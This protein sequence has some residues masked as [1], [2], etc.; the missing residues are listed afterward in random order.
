M[1]DIPD[2]PK[3][4]GLG[5][6]L[7][8]MFEICAAHQDATY[9]QRRDLVDRLRPELH[10][11]KTHKDPARV[12]ALLREIMPPDWR[13][14]GQWAEGIADPRGMIARELM[15]RNVPTSGAFG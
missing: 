5:A 14:A 9:E 6:I 2:T 4:R 11:F 8:M 7:T 15:R 1:N 10:R 12:L 3:T 13:P